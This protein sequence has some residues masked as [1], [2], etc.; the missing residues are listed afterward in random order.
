MINNIFLIIFVVILI[1]LL[2]YV[3]YPYYNKNTILM[4]NVYNRIIELQ[5]D[6]L[7][8]TY[9][10]IYI[11][12]CKLRL[13]QLINKKIETQDLNRILEDKGTISDWWIYEIGIPMNICYLL[14]TVNDNFINSNKI[15]IT[16]ILN[17]FITRVP[18]PFV[19]AGNPNTYENGSNLYYKCSYY[20]AIYLLNNKYNLNVSLDNESYNDI[21]KVFATMPE[22][23]SCKVISSTRT[24]GFYDDGSYLSSNI[25]TGI[26]NI[27]S[28]GLGGLD[29]IIF[30]KYILHLP[31]NENLLNLYVT[32]VMNEL[33]YYGAYIDT[34]GRGF[35]RHRAL[36]QTVQVILQL[37]YINPNAIN[38]I[39]DTKF[40]THSI[41]N[42]SNTDVKLINLYPA[43]YNNVSHETNDDIKITILTVNGSARIMKNGFGITSSGYTGFAK[44]NEYYLGS[45]AY[46]DL[47]RNTLF[48]RCCI[49]IM[50]PNAFYYYYITNRNDSIIFNIQNIII[51]NEIMLPYLGD[52]A[53]VAYRINENELFV[54][55]GYTFEKG[56]LQSYEILTNYSVLC[57]NH[58]TLN[59][60]ELLELVV[61][62]WA[63]TDYD[64]SDNNTTLYIENFTIRTSA[65][66]SVLN[67]SGFLIFTI[68]MPINN[69]YILAFSINR[70]L[71]IDLRPDTNTVCSGAMVIKEHRENDYIKNYNFIPSNFDPEGIHYFEL[72]NYNMG[73]ILYSPYDNVAT[74]IN[75][76]EVTV[77]DNGVRYVLLPV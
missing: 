65:P 40:I 51:N 58:I 60:P 14:S 18:N 70:D 62:R 76:V 29:S 16:K 46:D 5:S 13:L 45:D 64:F 9:Y 72:T 33:N 56:R 75:D 3:N 35:T 37:A 50:D 10:D 27:M 57:V 52:H 41:A 7:Y 31:I 43:L 4:K 21:L 42:I 47:V 17:L 25:N 32:S 44:F 1:I 71:N 54:S 67:I 36:I 61:F 48:S 20:L 28:Y 39:T 12:S 22:I 55:K 59:A 30:V 24:F 23:N 19:R 6:N 34:Y 11:L 77:S 63:Y 68:S 49:Q 53:L 73:F 26:P 38:K 15:L 69:D 66:M 74:N 2:Y 8:N